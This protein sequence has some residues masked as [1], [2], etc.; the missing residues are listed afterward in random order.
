[1][2]HDTVV[3]TTVMLQVRERESGK[4]RQLPDSFRVPVSDGRVQGWCAGR[5]SSTRRD[6]DNRPR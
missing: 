5:A 2:S 6:W 3:N 1:M 4:S